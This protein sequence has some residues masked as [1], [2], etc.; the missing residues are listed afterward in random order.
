M[1][2]HQ[3]WLK[4]GC[5]VCPENSSSCF[6]YTEPGDGW[7]N[8]CMEECF[9]DTDDTNDDE[10]GDEMMT[11]LQLLKCVMIFVMHSVKSKD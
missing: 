11:I 4:L 3:H 10:N 9:S 7:I 1:P 6:E 2:Y 8:T 5:R